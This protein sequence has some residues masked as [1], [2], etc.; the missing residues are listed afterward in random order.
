MAEHSGF[1]DAHLVD[2]KYDRV[3]L[4]E[5]FAKYIASLISNGI[6][7]G[8]SSELIVRQK[9]TA[10]MSINVLPGRACI[11]GYFY[12]N[13][14][15]LSLSIDV[16]DGVLN[17]IDSVVLRWD[18]IERV[19]RLAVKKGESAT[20]PIA[21]SLQR[22]ADY[23]ELKLAEIDI[24]AGATSITQ[25]RITDTRLDA[26]VCGF[27]IGAVQ[28]FDTTEFGIQ[29]NGVIERLEKVAE[30]NDIASLVFDM[31]KIERDFEAEQ[32]K[33]LEI[34]NNV[35][36]KKITTSQQF[37]VPKAAKQLFKIFAVGGG[38]GGG[39][40]TK[41]VVSIKDVS[42]EVE[43]GGGG[44]GGG[45]IEIQTAMCTE[46]DVL[47]ITVGAGGNISC[48]GGDT[49]IMNL[50]QS[51]EV[52]KANGG[53]AGGDAV[54]NNGGHGGSGGSGGGGGGNGYLTG[55]KGV[56]GNGGDGCYGGGGAGYGGL[57]GVSEKYGDGGTNGVAKNRA[58]F[59]DNVGFVDVL[60]SPEYF[61]MARA[62]SMAIS[63]A[64]GN[65]EGGICAVG[66]VKGSDV[67]SGCGGGGGFC[68]DGGNGGTCNKYYDT[69][70]YGSGGG[71]GGG[72]YCG[73]GGLGGYGCDYYYVGSGDYNV[74]YGGGGGGGGGFFC[75]G[76]NGGEGKRRVGSS[77]PR[78]YGGGGGG[79]FNN[80]VD[81]NSIGNDSAKSGG[82]G[83]VIIMYVK[84]EV[85]L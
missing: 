39:K 33:I 19:I 80:G 77:S 10:N 6:F 65:G 9:E 40:G 20:K 31:N 62:L 85:V 7:G 23:Y 73:N 49:T 60:F 3:Y 66:G 11:N 44:G 61:P 78:F 29:I 12:E 18:N 43:A 13:T 57:P 53:K 54:D 50:T 22:D 76:G 72:G 34:G 81:G 8:K 47:E 70:L 38:G 35:V 52:I 55:V 67:S 84:E 5:D 42:K 37:T 64:V 36:I 82:D 27:V 75:K 79:F 59:S 71:G 63:E 2:G 69:T 16:A 46:G 48:D 56:S 68:R 4:A 17:R 51:L 28:N 25:D 24:K 41:R 45:C 58:P 83:G 14:D 15:E 30:E 26:E 32:N 74:G 1:F 21:P